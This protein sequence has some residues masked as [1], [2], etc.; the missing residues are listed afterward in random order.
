MPLTVAI[1]GRPNVGKSTLFNRLVGKR[2]AIVDDIPG[3]TR[4][5]REGQGRLADRELALIDT[6]G[7]EEGTEQALE[8]RMRAQTLR[9]VAEADVT[10]LLVDGRAGLTALDLSFVDWLRR[11]ETPVILVVNKCEG[12]GWEATVAEAYG[13]G[14]GDPIPVSAEHGL[15]MDGL[16]D[17]LFPAECE[18]AR[19]AEAGKDATGQAGE[20]GETAAGAEEE[21]AL[22]LAIV[23][24][25][26]VG[27]STLVNR[28]LGDDRIV[29]GPEAGITRDTIRV[30]WEYRG[31]RV[32]LIDTAGLRR[33]AR[34]VERLER[35]SG[36]DTW[37]AVRFAHV[38]VVMIDATEDLS[39]QDLTIA[40]SAV[41]EGRALVIAANKWDMVEDKA[42]CLRDLRERIAE[43]LHQGRGVPVVAI[44][45]RTGQN[46]ERLMDAVFQAYDVWNRRVSTG[47]LNR[48]LAAMIDRH[49]PPA[50]GGRA[51]RLRYM[52]QVSTRPPTFA[53]FVSRPSELPESYL[54]YL[55]NALREDFAIPGVPIRVQLRRGKNPYAKNI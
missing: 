2:V 38:V 7:F 30:E 23:G 17:A 55:V 13:L 1:V 46:L 4:D 18:A 35:K 52:T 11:S 28:L 15:G 50:P 53:L 31:R 51:I 10:L 54:R 47:R 14:L 37:Q 8:G 20:A 39:K 16:Y 26:N 6:A 27:K 33:R 41:E 45:A 21:K 40:R 43:S 25:P 44:S 9:A 12:K 42:E 5:R 29:T 48:W 19:V 22:Q 49:P 24:R 32:R 36:A 3:V 34:V